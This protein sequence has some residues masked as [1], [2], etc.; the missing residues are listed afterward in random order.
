MSGGL[1][2]LCA[3]VAALA[4]LAAFLALGAPGSGRRGAH[5]ATA[6][7]RLVRRVLGLS[8]VRRAREAEMLAQRRA[9]CLSE[10]Q[11]GRAP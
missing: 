2:A 4:L 6:A 11:I 8:V 9:A 3:C 10:L 1:A 5:G 7:G